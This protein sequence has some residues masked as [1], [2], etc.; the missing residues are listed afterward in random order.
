[1]QSRGLVAHPV[2]FLLLSIQSQSL[3]KRLIHSILQDEEN[4][5]QYTLEAIEDVGSIE[6]HVMPVLVM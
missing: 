4:E 5:D 2:G 3:A 1:V 6:E